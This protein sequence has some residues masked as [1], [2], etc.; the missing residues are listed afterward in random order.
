VDGQPRLRQLPRRSPP[1]TDGGA[2]QGGN[3]GGTPGQAGGRRNSTG[4]IDRGGGT[5]PTRD[6]RGDRTSSTRSRSDDWF[7]ESDYNRYHHNHH[8][9]HNHHYYHYDW[10]RYHPTWCHSFGF[11]FGYDYGYVFCDDGLAYWYIR[12]PGYRARY[13]PYVSYYSPSCYYLPSYYT[14]HSEV[15]VVTEFVDFPVLPSSEPIDPGLEAAELV[16]LGWEFFLA[17][18]YAGAGEAFRQAV[19]AAPDDP[20]PKLAFAQA[21]FAI[22]NYPDAA[23]VFRRGLELLPDWPALAENPQVHYADPVDHE[24]QVLALETF[25][26]FLPDDPS[27]S[28][29][30]AIQ[31]FLT[32]HREAAKARFDALAILDP[33][34][35]AVQSFLKLY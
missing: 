7:H 11:S 14:V 33:E 15:R 4:P 32:G 31:Q 25:L 18:D 2:D 26:D 12:Y 3:S 22:G 5:D 34:D 24:E 13:Y 9:D 1:T 28:F 29:L 20:W 10:H 27:A 23:F 19:L 35:L 30:L 17:R 6:R 8:Y 16:E 21:L